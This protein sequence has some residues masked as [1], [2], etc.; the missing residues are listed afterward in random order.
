[1][2]QESAFAVRP[3]LPTS[4]WLGCVDRQP[5]DPDL[6]Q[7]GYGQCPVQEKQGG[8]FPGTTKESTVDRWEGNCGLQEMVLALVALRPS[9]GT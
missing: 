7:A 1:M 3:S 4:C 9:K 8:Q 5:F 2:C 6:H